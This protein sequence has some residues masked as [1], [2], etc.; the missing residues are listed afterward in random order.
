MSTGVQLLRSLIENGARSEFRQLSESLFVGDEIPA[1]QF[2]SS[3]YRRHGALPTVE[4]CQQNGVSLPESPNPPSYYLD[5][6]RSRAVFNTIASE[7]P[8]L[9]DA[10]R[11]RDMD[12]ALQVLQRTVR[13]ATRFQSQNDI[14][15]IGETIE[16]VMEEY[17]VAHAN[18]GRQGITLGW[19]VLDELT[20]GA[21]P[22]DVIT[23]VARPGMGKSWSMIHCAREAWR[24]G[25]SVLFV[26]MEM[27][28]LQIA[29]RFLGLEAGVNPDYVRRG[30]LSAHAESA[31]YQRIPNIANGAP[32][33]LL[34]GE[35]QKSVPV[36]DSAVQEFSPDIV[37]IDASYLMAPTEGRGKR[38]QWEALTDVG[39]EVKEMALRRR[40]PVVQSVQFN[41]E[42]KKSKEVDLAHIGGSDVVGQISSIA[43]AIKEGESPNEHTERRMKIMKNR[44]G[45]LGE[46]RVRFLFDPPSFSYIPADSDEGAYDTIWE[47]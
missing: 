14:Y 18:P 4:A 2:V 45:D 21:E 30:Q 47:P 41:R 26:T 36:V 40:K 6:I 31:L 28:A 27:T 15:T 8:T 3:F 44:E 9:L 7:Q 25:N 1:Y 37:Y 32:F 42:V 17:Q 11:S 5:R 24:A 13:T 20:G 23:F 22:G 10:M 33:H 38:S 39:K 12:Q 29:R 34:A 43:I 16:Q 35:F 19:P 46:F